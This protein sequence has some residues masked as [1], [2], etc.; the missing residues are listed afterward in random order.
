MEGYKC[1]WRM[2]SKATS[3]KTLDEGGYREEE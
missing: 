3:G 2:R 1:R